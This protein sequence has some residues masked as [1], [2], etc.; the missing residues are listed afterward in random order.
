[1]VIADDVSL[2]FTSATPVLACTGS[3]IDDSRDEPNGRLDP[4]ETAALVVSV[5]NFG[6]AATNAV[7]TLSS[8]DPF[9]VVHDATALLGDVAAGETV[10]NLAD[11]LTIE[12]APGAP[13]GHVADLTLTVSYD[14]GESASRL[15]LSIGKFNF[16]VWDPTSDQSSGPVIEATLSS[17]GF[18]GRS[19]GSLVSEDLDDYSTLFVSVGVYSENYIILSGSPEAQAILG[20]LAAGGGVYLE[21]GDVWYFD[22]GV[23]GHNF[24]P[25][26]G[27]IANGDG[28]SDLYQVGGM[29]GTF[30]AGMSFSHAGENN[31]ID[32]LSPSAG[33]LTILRNPSL[34]YG[35]GIARDAGT[36]R[37]I[38]AS[39]EFAGL[40]DGTPPSTKAA[41]A[42]EIMGFLLPEASA[43][44]D[45]SISSAPELSL[46]P[47]WP[48]LVRG[49]AT[50]GFEL[51]GAAEV[52]IGLYD[53]GGRCLR[54]LASG[55]REAG[56]HT[57]RL[58]RGD[59]A[60]GVYWI[61]A[62]SG[63]TSVARRCVIAR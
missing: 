63:E 62:Q 10:R 3:E 51:P 34:G 11:P 59:L 28:S 14:G 38:G 48:G 54:L 53:V 41:L 55:P 49:G 50:L 23:G 60:S 44:P 56:V 6:P 33:S 18:T 61:R 17:L 57:L 12:A 45:L 25:A 21:G 36:Y 39:F 29:A 27:I 40:V 20:F 15:Q 13:G 1:M 47:G 31:Y 43:A 32:R 5:R 16:L 35:C 19:R 42:A 26:F 24:C 58:E 8:E 46:L 52:R 4:G 37:T 2:S 9:L 30:T 7:T 22:P